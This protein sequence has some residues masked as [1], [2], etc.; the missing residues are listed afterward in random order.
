MAFL[1]GSYKQKENKK[2]NKKQPP[3]KSKWLGEARP[4]K[5]QTENKQNKT[6]KTKKEGLGDVR[7]PEGPPHLKPSKTQA[8][9]TTPP[10]KEN[11]KN[12]KKVD[13]VL[14]V[15]KRCVPKTLAFAFGL[16]LR[17]KTRCFKTRVLG[18][19]LPNG[20]PQERLR[21]RALR[22]KTPAFKKRIAISFC[23]LKT[24]LGARAC[25]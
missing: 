14:S 18:R 3:Q 9:K 8:Q 12:N 25:V 22:S 5:T 16:R 24:S 10:Q 2:Q 21:F 15:L 13:L 4:S 6:K 17:S 1:G 20:K 19:R 11:N 7:W 23:D